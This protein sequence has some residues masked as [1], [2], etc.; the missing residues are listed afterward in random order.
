[1]DNFK[2]HPKNNAEFDYI[3]CPSGEGEEEDDT[4]S[5]IADCP[6]TLEKFSIMSYMEL[7]S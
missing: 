4:H 3:V 1:M 6:T 5:D 7:L 2:S